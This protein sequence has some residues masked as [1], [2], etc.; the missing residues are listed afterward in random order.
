MATGHDSP[1]YQAALGHVRLPD[2]ESPAFRWVPTP[3]GH[4][5]RCGP[6]EAYAQHVFTTAQLE[7]P[8]GADDTVAAPAWRAAAAAAQLED[9]TLCRLRQVHGD[10]IVVVSTDDDS[11]RVAT[12]RPEGDSLISLHSGTAIGVVVADCVPLLLADIR[13]RAVAAVHAGWRGTCAGIAATTVR[14]L[15][16]VAGVSPGELVVAIG[17]SIGRDDYEVG[18]ALRDQFRAAGH[19]AA[20]VQRWF[21]EPQPGALPCLD[22]WRA[23]RDQLEA[24]GVPAEAIHVAGLSTRAHAPLLASF[25]RDGAMAGRMI[26]L[27]GRRRDISACVREMPERQSPA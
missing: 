6:L 3:W 9:M 20:S 27:I 10:H 17:P 4:G 8:A 22:L 7:L 1:G 11:Q 23:N 26:A 2:P 12:V 18:E 13:G 15:C 21:H 16:E 25:R 5:L 14:S 24:T 19:D